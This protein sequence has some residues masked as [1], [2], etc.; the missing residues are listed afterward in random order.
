MIDEKDLTGVTN[1]VTIPAETSRSPLN[2][3]LG[4]EVLEYKDPNPQEVRAF[5]NWRLRHMFPTE[6]EKATQAV[7][8]GAHEKLGVPKEQLAVTMEERDELFRSILEA[9]YEG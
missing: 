4:D 3:R 5:S 8:N 2:L 7:L 1:E 9:S 6:H